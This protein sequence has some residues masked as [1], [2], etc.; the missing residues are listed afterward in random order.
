MKHPR[1]LLAILARQKEAVLTFYLSCI[2]A[3]DYPKKSIVLYVRANNSSDATV[4][5]LKA[6]I[7]RT[8]DEYADIEMDTS[9]VP[10]LD[11]RM[12]TSFGIRARL[13]QQSLEMTERTGCEFYFVADL[14]NFLRPGALTSSD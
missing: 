8:G 5:I 7:Y 9:D 3:L 1:V 13:R 14:D 11:Q 2:E 4:P 12:P 10:G 6:W